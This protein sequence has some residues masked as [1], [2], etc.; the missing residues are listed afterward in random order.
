MF[1]LGFTE[2]LVIG[3]LALILLGPEQ[4]PDLA[5]KLGRFVND[6]KRTTDGLKEEF[7][8]SGINPQQFLEDINR[9]KPFGPDNPHPEGKDVHPEHNTPIDNTKPTGSDNSGKE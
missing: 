8:N 4:L 3:V 6:L 2:V 1:G 5:R 7:K 9:E